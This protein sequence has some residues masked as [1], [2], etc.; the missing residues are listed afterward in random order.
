MRESELDSDVAIRAEHVSKKFCRYL[1]KSMFYG[2]Q[3]MGRNLL[4]ISSRSENLRDDEFWAVDDVSFELRRGETLGIIGPNGSGKSTILKLLNGIFMPD[5]GRIEINGRV[6]ALISVG[7]GFHPMLSGRENIYVNSA[8]L[9]MSR[10][11][12]DAKF[13]DIVEFADIGDFLDTPVKFYSSGMFVRLGL[14]VAVH[15]ELDILLVDEVLAVGDAAF[16]AKSARKMRELIGS[17]R[18]VVFISHNMHL[19]SSICGRVLVLDSGK[20]LFQGPTDEGIKLYERHFLDK[21]LLAK[22]G[23]EQDVETAVKISS[24]ELLDDSGSRVTEIGT[25]EPLSIHVVLESTSRVEEPVFGIRMWR[26]DGTTC[27]NEKTIYNH[28]HTGAVDGRYEFSCRLEKVQT[29]TGYYY[30][31]V[32]VFEE[33]IGTLLANGVS[34]RFFVQSPVPLRDERNDIYHPLLK[35]EINRVN[36]MR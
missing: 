30:F 32:N 6:G 11:E 36:Q 31:T 22:H 5:G 4:G 35:W 29:T 17:D 25:D 28:I 13:N 18:A 27:W 33:R 23:I 12:T 14:A 2:L 3:D 26:L 10:K 16:Q 15:C 34:G 19:V 9:G 20:S 24:I 8:I 1:R 7:A 21:Q